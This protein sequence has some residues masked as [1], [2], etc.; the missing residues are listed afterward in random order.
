MFKYIKFE[1]AEN[2]FTT[3]EFRGDAEGVE[4]NHFDVDVVSIKGEVEADIDALI[5]QQPAEINCTEVTQDEFK[6]LVAES[7]QML[8]IY[9][10]CSE[11]YENKMSVITSKYPQIEMNTWG[12]QLEQA[13]KF[14]ASGDES[15]A[16]FLKT[17][18]TAEGTTVDDFA[19]AVVAKANEYSDFSA[20]SLAKKR[21]LK[22]TLLEEIGL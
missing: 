10:M 15:D 20:T 11:F 18:A 16:P 8:R 19:T 6:A 21:D 22:R 7:A 13:N 14:L 3:L 12:I 17:L 9:G 1:K 5:A 4:V 2:E